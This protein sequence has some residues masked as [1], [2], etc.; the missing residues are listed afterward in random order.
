MKSVVSEGPAQLSLFR[1]CYSD[2]VGF[3]EVKLNEGDCWMFWGFAPKAFN[4]FALFTLSDYSLH[5]LVQFPVQCNSDSSCTLAHLLVGKDV[6]HARKMGDSS[7][8]IGS[9]KECAAVTHIEW[10]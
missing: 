10:G 8:P 2:P 9:K 6:P 1:L 7:S 3:G 5:L 4:S